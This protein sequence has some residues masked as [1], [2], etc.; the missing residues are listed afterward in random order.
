MA[1]QTTAVPRQSLNSDKVGNPKDADAIMVQQ[2]TN[3][4]FCA[5]RVHIVTCC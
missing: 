2:Q 5:V 4:V 3:G 1:M